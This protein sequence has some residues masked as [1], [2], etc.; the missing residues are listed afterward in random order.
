[1]RQTSIL[2]QCPVV[3]HRIL[4]FLISKACTTTLFLH[5]TAQTASQSA[6]V[7]EKHYHPQSLRKGL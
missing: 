6:S 3:L 1:M 5:F 4:T 2:A 7:Q